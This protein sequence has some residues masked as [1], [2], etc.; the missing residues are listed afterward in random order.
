MIQLLRSPADMLQT[1]DIQLCYSVRGQ[2]IPTQITDLLPMPSNAKYVRVRPSAQPLMLWY[3]T[4][5]EL[6]I[7]LGTTCYR[8]AVVVVV[9][10]VVVVAAAAV[11]VAAAVAA[12]AA[13]AAAVVAAV[14][15]AAVAAAVSAVAAA[16]AAAAAAAVAAAAAAVAICPQM[17]FLLPPRIHS[18]VRGS[19]TRGRCWGI[20]LL[21][22]SGA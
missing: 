16:A 14:A 4:V 13:V 7:D 8:T 11:A 9:V 17:T 18:S 1:R 10:V 6:I 20:Q 15:A 5:N 3:C 12:P 22:Q 21:L 19:K 2:T